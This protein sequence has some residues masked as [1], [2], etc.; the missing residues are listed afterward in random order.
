[1]I[2]EVGYLKIHLVPDSYVADKIHTHI[3]IH[4]KVTCEMINGIIIIGQII[5]TL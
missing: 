3:H 1:M 2:T 5:S 4:R